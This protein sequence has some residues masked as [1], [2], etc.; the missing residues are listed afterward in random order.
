[1]RLVCFGALVCSLLMA[2]CSA[3]D[4]A[5]VKSTPTR[6]ET[7]KKGAKSAQSSPA[8][9]PRV[10]WVAATSL[11]SRMGLK[12][13]WVE[14]DKK[15]Q[16]KGATGVF[17]FNVDSRECTLRDERA[18]LGEAV[19]MVKGQP[20]FTR[21]DADR[22]VEPIIRPG[23]RQK[24]VPALKTIV[25]DPGHGGG[26]SGMVNKKLGLQEK[27][28][29]LD[30]AFRLKKLLEEE[31]Y[32]VIMTRSNDQYIELLDRPDVATKAEADL[33]VSI[34]FNSVE[35][36]AERVTGVEVFTMTPQYQLSADQQPDPQF[37]NTAQPGNA[38][39]HWNI[40][41]GYYMHRNLLKDL[42]VSDRGLKRGRLAVLRGATCP[43]VLVESGYLSNDAEAKKIAT[44]QYRQKI[45]EA[46]LD[47]IKDYGTALS[48]ARRI[49]R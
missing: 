23:S 10:E 42:G 14:Q 31:G 37:Q 27:V 45:A 28:L 12:F 43:A 3:L 44:P 25:L 13:S 19:R 9:A 1:V 29:A 8:T 32:K 30:T 20:S 2:S 26:D 4:S 18:F 41:I 17:E 40:L 36:G 35:Q 48:A 24:T 46:M 7:V 38:N 11:A 22:M 16:I 47:G 21:T 6:P 34:H 39:D 33:F 49:R 5:P 15:F